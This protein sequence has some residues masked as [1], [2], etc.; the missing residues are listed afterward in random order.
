M[1]VLLS[2]R[3][4]LQ[5]MRDLSKVEG[6]TA[7]ELL[8]KHFLDRFLQTI[9]RSDYG[10]KFIVKGGMLISNLTGISSRVTADIDFNIRRIVLNQENLSV[11]IEEICKLSRPDALKFHFNRI[12]KIRNEGLYGGYRVFIDVTF[13]GIRDVIKLDI[14]AGD[15]ITPG[16]VQM[17]FKVTGFEETF[18]SLAYNLETTLAE[19]I[20]TILSRG[21]TNT[22]ARDFYDVFVL[23]ERF[24]DQINEKVLIKAIHRTTQHRETVSVMINAEVIIEEIEKSSLL[25]NAWKNYQKSAPYAR[26]VTFQ[27]T[28]DALRFWMSLL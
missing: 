3:Q 23:M 7:P 18:T 13:D 8:K 6:V 19:K 22:R 26:L 10:N 20:E 28:I 12:T 15:V 4:L 9:Q 16:P 27:S 14:S 25:K 11:V 2:K 24:K 21:D 5:T 1:S 17:V